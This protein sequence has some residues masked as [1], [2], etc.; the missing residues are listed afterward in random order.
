MNIGIA[1]SQKITPLNLPKYDMKNYHF[2]FGVNTIRMNFDIISNYALSDSIIVKSSPRT[3][4]NLAIVANYRL[5]GFL[6]FRIIPGISLMEHSLIFTLI[7]NNIATEVSYNMES[8]YL[9]LPF[10]LKIK[11]KRI[12]NIRPY[13]IL[14]GNYRL[15]LRKQNPNINYPILKLKDVDYCIEFG[16]GLDNY[17]TYFKLSPELKFSFGFQNLNLKNNTV[18]S[19]AIDKMTSRVIVFNLLFE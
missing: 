4:I 5:N 14:G 16:F 7:N 19:R 15:S 12:H 6:D 17:L 8:T 10:L 2:G 18:Y 1:K 11:Y 3:G 9:D 13:M